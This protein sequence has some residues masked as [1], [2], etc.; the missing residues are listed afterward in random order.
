MS[1]IKV[2][3]VQM[4]TGAT[5]SNNIVLS[6]P[7]A[8][9]GTFK[10]S[11]GVAGATV[12]DVVTISATGNMVVSG[13]VTA[14]SDARLKEK[15]EQIDGALQK[16]LKLT[17]VTYNRVGIED[18]E[19]GVL[20]QEVQAVLPEAIVETDTGMLAVAYGNLIGLLIEAIKEQQG[21]IEQLKE[22]RLDD[23]R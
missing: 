5:A 4:G 14:F 22:A 9:D 12:L 23:M 18:R 21:Q 8:P 19:T 10:L 7:S 3:N 6:V 11:R 13:N 15:I 20:A 17:G 2:T 16:V 1:T